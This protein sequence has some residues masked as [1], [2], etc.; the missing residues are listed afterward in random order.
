MAITPEA[1]DALVTRLEQEAGTHPRGYHLKLGAFAALG[2]LYVIAILLLLAALVGGLIA[3]L[4]FTKGLIVVVQKLVIPVVVLIGIIGRS[5][6][7]KLEAPTGLEIDRARYPELFAAIDTTRKAAGA[8]RVHVVLLTQDL[9]A[10]VV[11]VPRLGLFGWQR[12]YLILGLPLL[13]MLS[14]PEFKAVLAHEF[15]HL[16]GAHGKFGAWIYRVRASWERIASVLQQEQ[17]WGRFLFVPFFSWYAPRFAAWSFVKARQQEYEA[18]R[19]AA[20]VAGAGNIASSLVRLALKGEEIQRHFW[21]G[22]FSAADT[23]PEPVAKPYR[24]LAEAERRQFLPDALQGLERALGRNTSNADTHPC[25]RERVR[26]LDAEAA[27]PAPV[28]QSAAEVLFGSALDGLIEHFDA[29]WS[30]D[31]SS[32]WRERHAFLAKAREQL[33]AFEGRALSDE[34]LESCAVNTELVHGEEKAFPLYEELL[35]RQPGRPAALFACG[36]LLLAR[37]DETGIALLEEAMQRDP[38]AELPGIE[39]ILSFLHARGRDADMRTYIERHQ[40][41]QAQ[42]QR[43][44]AE[45][46]T[47]RT[48]DA[49]FAHAM[50][51]DVLDRIVGRLAQNWRVKRAYLVQKEC[52]LSEAPL[53]VVGFEPVMPWHRFTSADHGGD[54]AKELVRDFDLPVEVFFIPF[55]SGNAAFRKVFKRLKAELIFKR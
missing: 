47:I 24:K 6:W 26:A 36:R 30:S 53:Y 39:L 34:E 27:V 38:N 55:N 13:Q 5:L 22:I 18:D 17:H 31:V 50:P 25:L 43:I 35:R 7:V 10:A 44:A 23:E 28:D 2:Y 21:P 51:S 33:A 12:N 49:F 3:V 41:R 29:S 45:R 11:Q 9:N 37:G 14:L 48:D 8:P 19:L 42:E 16:S 52:K 40:E 20:E 46:R 15:G 4:F 54:V 1:F 32:W